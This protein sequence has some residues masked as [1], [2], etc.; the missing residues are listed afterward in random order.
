VA[1][2]DRGNAEDRHQLGGHERGV[3]AARLIGCA[4][5]DRASPVAADVLEGL[6]PLAELE[7]LRRRHPELIEAES[8]E[9][10][11]D[12][13]QP[14]CVR[15]RQRLE[16]DAVDDAENRGIGANPERQGQHGHE[17]VTGMLPEM[18]QRV[19]QVLSQW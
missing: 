13:D 2:T 12:E 6:V 3:D 14:A 18:P 9:L 16:Q 15:I 7:E 19:E 11:R 17:R 1:A 4:E 8:G 10:A 5:V